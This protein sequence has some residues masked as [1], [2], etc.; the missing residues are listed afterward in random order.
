MLKE[1]C[2]RLSAS[3]QRSLL[4]VIFCRLRHRSASHLFAGL[5]LRILRPANRR[6]DYRMGVEIPVLSSVLQ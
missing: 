4:S 5:F 6:R 3:L 2:R 1:I